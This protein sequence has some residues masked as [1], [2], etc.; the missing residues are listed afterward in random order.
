MEYRSVARE[1]QYQRDRRAVEPSF[2]AQH[3]GAHR[4]VLA[5]ACGR[6][7]DA[8]DMVRIHVPRAG[9]NHETSVAIYR[10]GCRPCAI[11]IA[12]LRPRKWPR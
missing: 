8:R 12:G 11:E 3:P 9:F 6:V 4:A 1:M 2:P 5:C 7:L 10:I